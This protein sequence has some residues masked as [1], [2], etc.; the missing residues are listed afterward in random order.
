MRRTILIAL[1]AA[2]PFAGI[3]D[4]RRVNTQVTVTAGTPVRLSTTKRLVNRIFV[5]MAIGGSGVGYVMTGIPNGTTPSSSN[6]AHLT[7]QLCAA[8]ATAPGCNYSDNINSTSNADP[9][10]LSEIWLDG[11]TSGDKIIVSFAEK[12]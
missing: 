4:A 2:I 8:T 6:A 1:L 12:L 9:I 5:Q 3:L 10:D 11:A 7:A